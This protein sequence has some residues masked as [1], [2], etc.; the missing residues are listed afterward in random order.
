MA[1]LDRFQRLALLTTATTYL[2]IAV[3]GLVRASGAGLGC[4]DWP[5]CFGL[6][7]PPLTAAGLPP[8]FDAV[9]F[10]AAKTWTEY[11]NRL[12]GAVTGLLILATVVR[13]LLDH[14][15]RPRVWVP[16]LLAFVLVLFNG[17]LGGVVV[18]TGL[19]PWALTGHLV[20]AL[21]VVS[22]L[23]LAS[24]A[25]FFPHG[26]RPVPPARRALGGLTAAAL[27]LVLVQIG[28]GAFVR[29]LVQGAHGLPRSEWLAGVG[30]PYIAHQ[31]TA[32]FAA[33]LVLVSAGWTAQLEDRLLGRLAAAS[34]ALVV[35]QSLAGWGLG[36][37]AFPRLLQVLHLWGAALLLGSLTCTLLVLFRL[38]P[39]EAGPDRPT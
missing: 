11:L 19:H 18:R 8:G 3:G 31:S 4:P 10:N 21:L 1:R 23:L 12:L 17:W 16:S 20:G 9:D 34:A 29:G 39:R 24:V 36:A 7:I 35:G 28:L 22:L 37:F 15:A 13:A 14:R 6:W 25:A 5:K 32:L 33:A 27:L 30:A 2:L 38:D 26:P